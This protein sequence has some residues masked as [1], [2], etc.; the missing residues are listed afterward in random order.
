MVQGFKFRFAH[1]CGFSWLG[2]VTG[3]FLLVVFLWSCED[4]KKA[5]PEL[6]KGPIEEVHD[7]R[8]LYSEAGQL[9]VEVKTPV[10]LR[11]QNEDKTF[12]DTVNINFFDPLSQ[13]IVTTLRSDSGRFDQL[14][15]LYIVKGNVIVVNKIERRRLKTPELYWN[16]T[17]QKVFTEK[18]VLIENLL[19]GSYTKG[20]GLDASQ[21][22]SYM[23]IRK[24][25]G[26]FDF[27]PDL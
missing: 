17:T 27:E 18:D 1:T 15:N 5:D 9:R 20:K 6:Y 22:F 16:P 24:P 21:D 7:V 26:T 19:T 11:Y 12:P 23:S 4:D 10:Q 3:V 13:Q 8:I 14:K 25:Y 2:N